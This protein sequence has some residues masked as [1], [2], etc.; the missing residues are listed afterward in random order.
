MTKKKIALLGAILG[1]AFVQVY[2]IGWFMGD[3]SA[4]SRVNEMG[5][6]KSPS[7]VTSPA[8]TPTPA[9]APAPAPTPTNKQTMTMAE[10]T[11]LKN[12]MSYEEAT[13]IIG[14]PG[15]VMSESGSPGDAAHTVM[16]TYKGEGSLG[17]NANVMFQGNK[18][19]N[20]A[21]F[22]LK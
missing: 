3:S 5:K 4:V 17:A 19:M 7:S 10:F 18:L 15:E 14:G 21:Q 20:K 8:V 13:K 11:Q 12:G 9:V 22:G 16:Y 6:A 2:N 1:T